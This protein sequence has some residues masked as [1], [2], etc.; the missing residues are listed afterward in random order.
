LI[1]KPSVFSS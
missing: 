1:P